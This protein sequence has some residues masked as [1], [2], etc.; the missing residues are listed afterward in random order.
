MFKKKKK[1]KTKGKFYERCREKFKI[2]LKRGQN[3]S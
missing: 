2:L 1:K 3:L